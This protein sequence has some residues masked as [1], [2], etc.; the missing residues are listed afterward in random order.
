MPIEPPASPARGQSRCRRARTRDRARRPTSSASAAICVSTVR[1]PVPMS[2]AAIADDEPAVGLARG[3]ASPAGAARRVGR[4]GHAGADQP[5]A[6]AA[7]AGRGS[8]SAQPKRSAP[9]RRQATRLRLLNGLPVSGSTL[10]LVADAQLDRVEPQRD[11]ELVHRRLER[12]HARALAGRAHPRR[13]RHVERDQPVRRAA[14]RRRVHHAGGDAR[15]ARRTRLTVERLLDDVVRD[16]DEPPV[17]RRRRAGAAGSSACG[18]RRA[19]NICWRGERRAS[20]AGRRPA[21]PSRRARR[22][23]RRALGAEAAADVRRRSTRTWPGSSPK[24]VRERRLHRRATPWLE[25]YS[26][27]PS[28]VPHARCVACGSIGLLCYAGVR[29]RRVD[30]RP[31][32]RRKRA[33]RSRRSRGV[34]REARR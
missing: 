17:A 25:S 33:R 9:S 18:S 12:E 30:A 26:V 23:A 5:A 1:A 22:R 13:R 31:R 24:A 14:V 4:R 29:V 34:G 27:E 19:A 15:S 3:R 7:R 10:G 16:R 6:V 32:P 20:P 2:A 28:A 11:R 8:R 21:R